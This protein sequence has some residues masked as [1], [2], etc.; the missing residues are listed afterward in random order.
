MV[1][2]LEKSA[3]LE[4]VGQAEEME[5]RAVLLSIAGPEVLRYGNVLKRSPEEDSLLDLMW[6]WRPELYLPPFEHRL[7]PLDEST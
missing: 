3:G 4:A 6:D 7:C 2:H 1:G 5:D